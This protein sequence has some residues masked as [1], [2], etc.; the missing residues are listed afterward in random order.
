MNLK[1]L[2]S[3]VVAAGLMVGAVACGA[4]PDGGEPQGQGAG[5]GATTNAPAATEA[6]EATGV[7]EDILIT[8]CGPG[9]HLCRSVG[10][11]NC[12]PVGVDCPVCF[13]VGKIIECY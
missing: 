10:G 6:K 13:K 11:N 5:Q 1:K 9:E 4:A 2:V 8:T 7:H 3:T 12:Q